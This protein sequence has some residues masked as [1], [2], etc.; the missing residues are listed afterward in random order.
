MTQADETL[1]AEQRIKSDERS[2][3]LFGLLVWGVVAVALAGLSYWIG[4]RQSS[5]PQAKSAEVGFA[6]DM[7]THHAQAVDM[8]ILLRDRSD[9][10][11]LK[12]IALD[13]ALTQQAQIGQMQGWLNVWGHPPASA[14]PAMSWMG[15]PV[16]GLM[17]GIAPAEEMNRLR[18]MQ[19]VE[20]DILFLQL[21]ITHHRAGVDMAQAALEQARQ[22]VVRNLA[23]SILDAQTLEI[24]LLESLLAEKGG[25]PIEGA[26]GGMD[27]MPGVEDMPVH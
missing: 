10:D 21:M 27:S 3:N 25:A 1:P 19:G 8:A 23:Q 16:S 24:E 11:R 6:R 13:I 9:D 17:P 18:G 12:Q 15:A 14:E 5:A 4:A 2:F 22:P 7:I 20:A 26:P